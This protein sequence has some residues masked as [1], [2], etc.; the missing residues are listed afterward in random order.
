LLWDERKD[1][2]ECVELAFVKLNCREPLGT[3]AIK[4]SSPLFTLGRTWHVERPHPDG[5]GM[6]LYLYDVEY[7]I[8]DSVVGKWPVNLKERSI[9]LVSSAPT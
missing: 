7:S 3:G 6:M 8:G 4:E 2:I 9:D 1:E 5:I